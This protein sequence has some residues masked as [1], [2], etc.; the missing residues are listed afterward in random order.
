MNDEVS[1]C[2][3]LLH[4][5]VED[6]EITFEE[7]K[8]LEI[9]DDII[10]ILRLLTHDDDIPYKEYVQKIKDSG[11]RIAKAVKLA[12]LRHNSDLTRFSEVDAKMLDRLEKYKAAIELLEK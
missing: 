8:F 12:D 5:V 1:A 7:L 11:N 9:P 6:T 10:S 3:A 2:A 4:D